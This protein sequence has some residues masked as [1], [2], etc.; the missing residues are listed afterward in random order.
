MLHADSLH[1]APV[2]TAQQGQRQ[3][4][5]VV[6]PHFSGLGVAFLCGSV[7]KPLHL[8]LPVLFCVNVA[9]DSQCV[10]LHALL[11]QVDPI[12]TPGLVQVSQ[13]ASIRA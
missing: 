4:L 7:A 13:A 3:R 12:N 6:E 5:A 11:L 1:W 9:A 8:Y 10:L 2:L